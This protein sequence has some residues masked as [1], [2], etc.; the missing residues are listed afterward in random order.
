MSDKAFNTYGNE[1]IYN[2]YLEMLRIKLISK[3]DELGLRASGEY[4]DAL[5]LEASPT[6]MIMWGSNHSEYMENGRGAGKFPPYNPNTGTFDE[7]SEW[8]DNKGILPSDFSE[9]KK[10]FV[11]LVARKIATEG[12]KVP[13]EHNKGKVI[14]AVVDD[15]LANDINDML[16][17]LGEVFLARI[18]VDILQLFK[19]VA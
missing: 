3:Y 8:V 17:E 1:A 10:G 9:N 14:S 6:K 5:E 16:E 11:Y 7:I 19:Q 2:K 12:I 4:A 15:F 13:N 18:E